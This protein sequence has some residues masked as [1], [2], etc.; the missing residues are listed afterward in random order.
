MIP[1]HW[2]FRNRLCHH[3]A[4]HCYVLNMLPFNNVFVEATIYF[5]TFLSIWFQFTNPGIVPPTIYGTFY[6]IRINILVGSMTG[7]TEAIGGSHATPD[8][9]QTYKTNN[10]PSKGHAPPVFS[11]LPPRKQWP[12]LELKNRFCILFFRPRTRSS[13]TWLNCFALELNAS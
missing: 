13:R 1:C 3:T 11:D 8:M 9:N 6:C 12:L 5:S 4:L 10:F 7:G 2:K